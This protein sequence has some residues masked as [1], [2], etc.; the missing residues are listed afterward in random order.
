MTG[1]H[2]LSER[3]PLVAHGRALWSQ[4]EREHLAACPDC[5]EEWRLVSAAVALGAGVAE[6]LEPGAV[7]ARVHAGLTAVETRPRRRFRPAGWVA[8]AALAA[9]VA[10]TVWLGPGRTPRVESDVT[11]LPEIE[12]LDA[13]GLQAM[14]EMLPAGSAW[15][16]LETPGFADLT[17]EELESILRTLEG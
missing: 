13:T 4:T 15:S 6:R 10:L 3:I 17:E 14:L 2:A 1:C 8:A 16:T 11:L 5:A 9:A 7:A 12:P